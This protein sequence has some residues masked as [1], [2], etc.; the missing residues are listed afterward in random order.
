LWQLKHA[1]WR[2]VRL[3]VDTG[4]HARKLPFDSAVDMLVDRVKMERPSAIGEI[5]RYTTAPTQPSSYQLGRDLI[6]ETREAYRR[7]QGNAFSLRAFHDR[8]LSYGSIPVR[9]IRDDLLG[10]APIDGG[11][12][13]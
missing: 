6:M 3:I 5:T 7:R 10:P 2:A 12:P 8:F 11:P 9:L 4:I 13:A 1:L